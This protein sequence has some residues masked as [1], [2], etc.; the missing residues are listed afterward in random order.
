VQ[1][2]CACG[3]WRGELREG[4]CERDVLCVCVCARAREGVIEGRGMRARVME[5]MEG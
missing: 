4:V 2:L 1:R 5:E 3:C